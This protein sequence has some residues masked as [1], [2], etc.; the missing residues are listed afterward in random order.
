MGP[1]STCSFALDSGFVGD[2]LEADS[3]WVFYISALR[4]FHK[5]YH[6]VVLDLWGGLCD[7]VYRHGEVEA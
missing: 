2:T 1:F 3:A 5:H 6:L 4:S 7:I